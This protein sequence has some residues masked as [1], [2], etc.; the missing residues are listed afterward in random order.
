MK[1][2]EIDRMLVAEPTLTPSS[3]F[4]ASVMDAVR[5]EAQG[6]EPLSFPWR[7]AAPGLAI[8]LLGIVVAV[9]AALSGPATEQAEWASLAARLESTLLAQSTVW[10]AG[11]LLGSWIVVRL[12]L[13]FSGFER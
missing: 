6:P 2:D 4:S 11:T 7:R 10:L 9:I 3:G 12:S 8:C 1:H 13:R 5:R